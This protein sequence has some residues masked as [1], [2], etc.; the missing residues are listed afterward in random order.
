MWISAG[1]KKITCFSSNLKTERKKKCFI[2]IVAFCVRECL[3]NWTILAFIMQPIQ[4]LMTCYRDTHT[5]PTKCVR[6]W[7]KKKKL[8]NSLKYNPDRTGSYR[9]KNITDTI[10]FFCFFF[11]KENK[12]KNMKL[13]V[14]IKILMIF[15]EHYTRNRKVEWTRNLIISKVRVG[16]EDQ[17]WVQWS[18]SR[19]MSNLSIVHVIWV[20]EKRSKSCARCFWILIRIA[21]TESI[22]K[23]KII[24]NFEKPNSDT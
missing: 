16:F 13:I 18:Q 10:S 22:F 14:V 17:L 24:F 21:H 2:F 5:Q 3:T 1:Q 23:R 8:E 11:F 4:I 20:G 15:W 9:D 12:E 19:H 6:N 7:R